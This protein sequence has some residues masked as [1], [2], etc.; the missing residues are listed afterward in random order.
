MVKLAQGILGYQN[1]YGDAAAKARRQHAAPISRR[2]T[3]QCSFIFALYDSTP[4]PSELFLGFKNV[5]QGPFWNNS[6]RM[7]LRFALQRFQLM[8]PGWVLRVQDFSGADER[9]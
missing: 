1:Q 6:K 9:T 4:N 2:N 8:K 5:V 7:P 3:F